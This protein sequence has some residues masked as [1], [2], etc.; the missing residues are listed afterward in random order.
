VDILASELVGSF[1]L[2]LPLL[3]FPSDLQ[4][5]PAR[6][7]GLTYSVTSP[8]Y[9]DA[10][11]SGPCKQNYY[12]QSHIRLGI[13]SLCSSIWIANGVIANSGIARNRYAHGNTT[14]LTTLEL[15]CH[16]SLRTIAGLDDSV[17]SPGLGDP[18]K[19]HLENS[20]SISRVAR[21][22]GKGPAILNSAS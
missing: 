16:D 5:G 3:Q 18:S 20:Q 9:Q 13:A 4:S 22:S 15:G 10:S 12:L 6:N 17:K 21:F 14:Y 1:Y 8:G 7:Q 2:R 19:V 11:K